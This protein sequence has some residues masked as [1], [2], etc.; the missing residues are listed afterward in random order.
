MKIILYCLGASALIFGTTR[1]FARDPP[2]TMNKEWQEMTNEYL[3]VRSYP[4]L[5]P[6][7]NRCRG[8]HYKNHQLT[9]TPHRLKNQKQSPVYHQRVTTD[10]AWYKANPSAG[11]PRAQTTTS[12]YTALNMVRTPIPQS[13]A[14]AFLYLSSESRR[15]NASRRVYYW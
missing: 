1:Y 10:Q 4:Y 6:C 11:S 12:S 7:L 3:K 13:K 14:P 2:K 8:T 5:S 15:I 9:R